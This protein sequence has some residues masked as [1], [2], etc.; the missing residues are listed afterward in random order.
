MPTTNEMFTTIKL[1]LVGAYSFLRL[2][3]FTLRS[4]TWSCD[5]LLLNVASTRLLTTEQMNVAIH[6]RKRLGNEFYLGYQQTYFPN[7][8]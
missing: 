8:R 3:D 2:K 5:A 1:L 7:I 6:A 4:F